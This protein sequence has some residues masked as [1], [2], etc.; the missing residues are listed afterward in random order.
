MLLLGILLS[1]L[2]FATAEI[3]LESS[4]I[5]G[6]Y[7]KPSMEENNGTIVITEEMIQKKHYDSVAKIFED[8]PVSVVRHTAFGPIVDL[9]G[10]GE[11]TISRVKVMIDGTPINPLEET[12][13]TIPFDTIPVESI[14]KIEIVPGT[15]TTKYGG[16]TTGGYI[17]I[18]TKKDK[19]KNYITINADHASYHANSI[20]I[21]AGMNASKKLFVYA[22][23]AYQRKDG[24][25][26]KDHSDRNNFLGGF[27]Y[28]INAKHRIKGQGNLYREDL[29]ST[30]E[31]THEE[32][33]QDRRKAG[34]DTKIE[35]DR[36]FASLDYEYTPTSHFKIRANVNRAHFTRDVSMDAKQDQLVLAFMPRD[37]QGYFLHF[38]AGLLTDPKL[39]DVRPVLLNFESTMEGKF[40]EKNQ[41]GKLDGEWKYNQG[42]GHLQFG[43][44]YNEKKLNQDLKSISKPFTLKNQLGYLIQGDPAPEGYEDYTGK[45]I[46]PEEMFKIKFKD[47]P[48]ILETFLGLRREGVEKEKI[49]FQNYNKID[50]FKDTHALYLLN[51]YKITPKFNFRAGLRWEHS[52]YGSDRKNRM[53]LGVHN[54]QSS[55]MANRMA[56]AGLL[57][58]YQMEAYVQGK[59][60][61][62]DVDLSLKETHVKESSDN[63]G[64]EVGFSYQYHKKGKLYFRYERGF[65]SPLP[66]QL[67]NKD[68][69]TGIYYPSHVKSEKVDTIEMGI[70]HSLWNNTHIEA[71]TF[72]SLTKDEITNM[73]YNANNHMNMR[74]AYANISKTR[75][76]GFELNAEH[77]FDKLKIRESFSYVDAKIAKDT[78]FKDYYHSDYKVKSEKEFKDAP[79]YYKKGQQVPLVSKVKVTVGAEYQFT[80]KLSLGGNYNYVS[81]YDTREPGEGFQAKTYKV[82]GHGTLDLFG[83]YSFTDYAYVRF[84]V[85]NVL[86]EKYN[87][88]EDSHY[89]VPAPKQNYYAGFSY[90]F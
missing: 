74:W 88:R 65:L 20:G 49:D 71:T 31:V 33:K 43:Y 55:G 34:E 9:R 14:A 30:T 5:R 64:G 60:S 23:E 66:S 18:H 35:M 21:A 15:G 16:G 63:F 81:G 39:S 3:Q 57:N 46:A 51:D 8:S 54:A 24:Y 41:E 32:L 44:S 1:S 6:G 28:Q 38:D 42:K 7:Y 89:A 45:I 80:D 17:N 37:E 79:L 26:K 53:I 56:I 10:S 90:K 22:G 47:F 29:K 36:D 84:G 4:K 78:G 13:G 73:R 70:K 50:A 19:Q 82:K 69:L 67:T 75:R 40:K 52:E 86:G 62:L 27:D 72:F 77:I 58:E 25:R 85:N 76:L 59:L 12:H 68:F 87:L 61:Y 83:R 11:R 2:S 48:Q